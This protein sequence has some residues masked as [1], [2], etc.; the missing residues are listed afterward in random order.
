MAVNTT[1]IGTVYDALEGK[2]LG[3]LDTLLNSYEIDAT[4]K[5]TVIAQ[6][7]TT[8]LNLSVQSVQNQPKIDADI[9]VQDA[10]TALVTAQKTEVE[11]LLS[12]KEAQIIAQ[13][14]SIIAQSTADTA[15][16]G[17][18]ADILVQQKLSEA[19]RTAQ[20]TQAV[21]EATAK[22]A[23]NV[24]NVQKQ[25]QLLDKQVS[26]LDAD[27]LLV[28]AQ[29]DAITQQVI[30]NRKIKI[31]DGLLEC[32]GTTG[33]GGLTVSADMWSFVFKM[34]SSVIDELKT[35]KG[36][37]DA[38][39][40]FPTIENPAYG[41]YFGVSVTGTTSVDGFGGTYLDKDG[42]TVLNY[43]KAG[44]IVMYDGNKWKKSQ[45]AS[46]ASTTVSK[47]V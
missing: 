32:Y 20:I 41:D 27:T 8:I 40:A 19:E 36:M 23:Y 17:K 37:W 46:P 18:Q 4:Q 5:A 2:M 25:G 13:T 42:T 35:F 47:V 28:S 30:D 15:L 44:D 14:N 39:V 12:E 33:A 43:W 26:K 1:E 16:K 3:T 45:T 31:F 38:T 6:G 24:A 11:T 10:Q 21:S 34:A 22:Q 9:D 7:L 29:E